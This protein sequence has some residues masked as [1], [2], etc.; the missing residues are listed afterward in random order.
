MTQAASGTK[1]S[2]Y[3]LSFTA[4]GIV[5]G[6]IG[7]SPLYAFTQVMS[8]LQVNQTNIFGILSLIFWTLTL[9]IS[10]KYLMIIFKADNDGEG[11]IMALSGILR[12]TKPTA[13]LLLVTFIGVG[14]IIGDGMLTP[15]ISILS[16]VEGL[17]PLSPDLEQYV[18]PITLFI[19]VILFAGQ[20]LGTEK[21]GLLFAPIMLLWFVTI[22]VL[23]GIQIAHNPKV[24]MALSPHYAI[25]FFILEKQYAF[26]TLGGVFL[27]ITGGEALFADL[28]HFGKHPIRLIWFVLVLPALLICYFGQGALLLAH[29]QLVNNTFYGLVSKPLLPLLIALATLAT[30]VASQATL[31]AAFSILKQTC[32][33]NFLPRLKIIYT[34][35]VEKGQV[36]VPMINLILGIGTCALV[37]AFQSSHNLAAAYGIAINLD[38]LIT[39]VL[40][41]MIAYLCWSWNMVKLVVFPILLIIEL[42]FLAGNLPKF[43]HGGW[44][45]VAIGIVTILIMYAWHK[46]FGELREL[47]HRDSLMDEFILDELN[48]DKITRQ[49]GTRIYIVDPYDVEGKSLLNHLR[50]N[51]IFSENMI[52]LCIKIANIPKIRG[53]ER[54]QFTKKASGLYLLT[55]HYGFTEETN[56]PETL[57]QILHSIKLP[58]TLNG[59]KLFYFAEF[60]YVDAVIE[61]I[62]PF[63]NLQKKL[64]A[65]MVRNAVPDMQ[66]YHLPYTQTIIVG[67]Y[68]SI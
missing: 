58:F 50:I 37:L 23:G 25:A 14:L 47:H 21:I 16:A 41:A 5:F 67:S 57:E 49:P 11:G 33:L 68:Y 64:F 46:G 56:V 13:W 28:G 31:S 7:T 40:V 12:Q 55:L 8:H 48:Q 32:L 42:A 45:P 62:N 2:L 20:R 3:G 52:F 15:A 38:M 30:V 51:R 44:I 26:M 22:S 60:V 39:T 10:F 63:K 29:P 1:T 36:F 34:S 54:Y 9:I 18:V 17:K 61:K 27:V 66:F 53:K 6:D 24:L 4:L 35:K 65:L 59:N 19:L 43:L